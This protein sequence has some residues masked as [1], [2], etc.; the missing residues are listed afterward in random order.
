MPDV[1]EFAR[2]LT[3]GALKIYKRKLAE[4]PEIE[5]QREFS[6][7][8]GIPEIEDI[9]GTSTEDVTRFSEWERTAPKED[10]PLWQSALSTLTAPFRWFEEHVTEPFGAVVTSPFTPS[11]EGTEGMGWL[12]R[13]R[14]EYK[15][16]DDPNWSFLGVKGVVELLPWLAIPAVGTVGGAAGGAAARGVAGALGRFGTAGKAVGRALEY[17]P[18]GLM[19]KG[20]GKVLQVAGKQVSKLTSAK[21]VNELTNRVVKGHIAEGGATIN[22][23]IGNLAGREM[24]A[25]SVFPERELTISGRRLSEDQ[26][27]GYIRRN[28]D[29]LRSNENV[30]V[31]TWFDKEANK[32]YL[33][34]TLT[35]TDRNTAIALAE[36]KGQK[37]IF[38]LGKMTEISIAKEFGRTESQQLLKANK[39]F[40]A[41]VTRGF[42]DKLLSSNM[43]DRETAQ[44]AN[45]L[46]D[47]MLDYT[48]LATGRATDE[49]V[50]ILAKRLIPYVEKHIKGLQEAAASGEKL[51]FESE[52]LA[53][54]LQVYA[55]GLYSAERKEQALSIDQVMSTAH[56]QERAALP[57]LFG[58]P[59]E[60]A[61]RIGIGVE[62]DMPKFF[63]GL[64]EM[65]LEK[66]VKEQLAKRVV[67]K[68]EVPTKAV[69]TKAEGAAPPI[70]PPAK[71]A[72]PAPEEPEFSRF[73]KVISGRQAANAWT[74]TQDMRSAELSRR[75]AAIQK[76]LAGVP[77]EKL[78]KETYEKVWKEL[79]SGELPSRMTKMGFTEEFANAGVRR[80]NEVL[81]GKPY[82]AK[83]TVKAFLDALEGKPIPRTP[84]VKGGSAYSR[85]VH[86]FGEDTAEILA[87]K[88]R[89]EQMAS[90]L[91][92]TESAPMSKEIIKYLRDL[93]EVPRTQS[94]FLG[95]MFSKGEVEQARFLDPF[96]PKV[97]TLSS[98]EVLNRLGQG[99]VKD[100]RSPAQKQLDY[101]ALERAA[102]KIKTEPPVLPAYPTDDL[103]KQLALLPTDQRTKIAH[104]LEA[105]GR[106]IIDLA[107]AP[108][109]FMTS[110][111][112]SGLLRQGMI[113]FVRHPIEGFKS[114]RPMVRAL[115][116]DANAATIEA[117][118]R[119]RPHYAQLVDNGMY[120]APQVAG[121]EKV[122]ISLREEALM[123]SL[124]LKFP[125]IK[126]SARAFATGLNELRS[127]VAEATITAW[128]KAGVKVAKQDY[129]DLAQLIN[130]ASGRGTMP[131][132]LAG[133]GGLLNAFLFSPRL[134]LSRLQFPLAVL[135]GVTES[136]LVR[137][138]AM[139]MLMSFVGVGAGILMMGKASGAF[140][141]ELD[142]RS[143]D[144]GKLKVG[145]TRLDIWT[146]YV[147]Y[148]RFATNLITSQKKTEGGLVY[149]VNRKEILDR[150]VQTKLSPA[151]GLLN[152]LLKGETYLGEALPPKSAESVLGQLYQR[153]APLA[154]QDMIDAYNQGGGAE[155]F[156]ASSGMLGIGVVTYEDEV[157]R[158]RDKVAQEQYGM[159]WDELG[160]R[161]G[162][163]AQL[164]LEQTS[165]ELI[166]AEKEQEKRYAAGSPSTMQQWQ[167][168]GKSIEQTYRDSIMKASA[169]FKATG[170]GTKFREKVGQAATTRRI[171]YAA[172]A[173]RKEYQD[174]T[175]Y[176][177][178]PVSQERLSSMNPGDV[179]R[180]E[181][182]RMM[183]GDDMYDQYDNYL[184]DLADQRE[185]D[186]IQKFGQSALDYIEDYQ[187]SRWLDKPAE[188]IQLE[189][190]RDT[191]SP[192]WDI[193]DYI[194]SMY[195]PE[196]KQLSDQI[197]LLEMRDPAKARQALKQ[198]PQI[199]RAR[200]LIAMY[201]RA[202]REQD[203]RIA[204]AYQSFYG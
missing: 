51:T 202:L 30:S 92:G 104:Y 136:A 14:A 154:I 146:G 62:R 18:Y 184:F 194:W 170:D 128:E 87:S 165:Q 141:V 120:F 20:T 60:A 199:L 49:Q 106:N 35:L 196:L 105:S 19:E 94:S 173:K 122:A 9:T 126:H 86:V 187:G 29:V 96:D 11:I 135:P 12:E 57:Q 152:D 91:L 118:I 188:L 10:I 34:L 5:K 1:D 45:H 13:E 15:A 37:A 100:I 69:V 151:V 172:R 169:E 182:Y 149:S 71:R 110:F 27:K 97:L 127:R 59:K 125:G 179:A 89:M 163:K 16:W 24:Y 108:R 52:R 95:Q 161:H 36:E 103:A 123:S 162:R 93:P 80:I 177:N 44:R 133:H 61:E 150:F 88:T 43:I 73:W 176:Y 33:D 65:D 31:G 189:Q 25:V 41:D 98:N 72:P 158:T 99:A 68:A 167:N 181:Y 46:I 201:K 28:L 147:Q 186:F 22:P 76:R 79:G 190:A 3:P 140:D 17:S 83:A 138:E 38:D 90:Q 153:M 164:E 63:D 200:E 132:F 32:S 175:N 203:P 53:E 124:V 81:A 178:Q 145:D 75:A 191:L 56:R 23:K 139:Q 131:K 142:P 159:T 47:T 2:G 67:T 115:F 197:Y 143:A 40:H 192:Y 160:L 204:E 130:W 66:V 171:M 183:Y 134:I 119:A 174:I 157:K 4:L 113:L 156:I 54:R 116:S 50:S 155:A 129:K 55:K 21:T 7:M 64:A 82:E 77:P 168:E 198:F 42:V 26:V 8:S 39:L 102:G 148:C 144:F 74:A 112:L 101:W 195:P 109:T 84:G 58:I 166:D 185:R 121:I 85:L 70:K 107:N 48:T 114:V 180:K 78:T 6:T 117:N 137:K 111:D 193:T